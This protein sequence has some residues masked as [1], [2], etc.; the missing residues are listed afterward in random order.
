MKRSPYVIQRATH[1]DAIET[2]SKQSEESRLEMQKLF[3]FPDLI[4]KTEINSLNLIARENESENK[5][6]L[7][8]ISLDH[9]IE[10]FIS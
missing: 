3:N 5:K 10:N 8:F 9:S 6:I 7:A 2:I 4:R 1:C